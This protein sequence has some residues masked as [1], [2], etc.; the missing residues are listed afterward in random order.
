ME[1]RDRFEVTE[2]FMAQADHERCFYGVIK[3][4]EDA[5]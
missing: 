5:R 1:N 3:R 2:L 4:G